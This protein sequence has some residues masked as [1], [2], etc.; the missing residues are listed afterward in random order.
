MPY[1][2]LATNQPID[3]ND[4]TPIVNQ[5]ATVVAKET[6]KPERYVMIELAGNRTMLFAGSDAPLAFIV[7]KSI[8]LSPS[9]SKSMSL[10]LCQLLENALKI[11]SDR[12]YIEFSNCPAEYWGW[13]RSTFG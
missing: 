6:G 1:L 13:N 2:K 10:A 7:C 5:L 9:Q 4:V 12:V 3:K 8:G 11:P